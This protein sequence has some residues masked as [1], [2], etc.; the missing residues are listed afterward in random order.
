MENQWLTWAKQLQAIAST[1]LFFGNNPYDAQ[2]YQQISAI[3]NDM[4]S[5]LANTPVEKIES[6]VADFTEGYATPQV[7]VRGAVLRD[8]KVLL[9]KEST[10]GLWTLP[11]GYADVGISPKENVI[12]EIWEEATLKIS[13]ASLYGIRYKA[14]HDYDPDVRDFYKLF[15]LCECNAE[16]E[17][18]AD[19]VE[20]TDAGYF[21]LDELPPLSTGRVL[22]KDIQDAFE[23]RSNGGLLVFCD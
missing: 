4:L 7:D 1:G 19:G 5:V 21:A 15:F 14:R 18:A 23:Y 20:T 22:T 2:R 3:A 8:N 12:K 13:Q 6:L 16:S 9:V 11:G 10:D 17:P